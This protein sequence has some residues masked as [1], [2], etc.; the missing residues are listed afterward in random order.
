M[1]TDQGRWI[2]ALGGGIYLAA[3]AFGSDILSGGDQDS[4]LAVLA[5][6]LWVRYLE[7][8]MSLRR[9]LGRGER[10]AGDVPVRVELDV[11]GTVPSGT[12][13]LREQVARLGAAGDAARAQEGP[14]PGPLP[15]P[16]GARAAA[17]PSRRPR[18]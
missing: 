11:E 16:A 9:T 13:L 10:L 7:R 15:A 14:A 12:L 1:L 5:A 6:T 3:W 18:S 17:I 4:V 8:P 2:L